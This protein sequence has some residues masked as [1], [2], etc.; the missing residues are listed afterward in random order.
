VGAW[1]FPG[2]PLL[3]RFT[4]ADFKA[5]PYLFG[6]ARDAEGRLYVGNTDGVLRM[7]GRE[8]ETISLPGGMAGGSLARGEDGRV[9]LAGY[10]SFG[11]IDTAADGRAVYHDLRDAFGLKGAARSLG[12]MGQVLPVADGIYF[13]S[14]H[15]LLFYGFSGGCRQWRVAEDNS[16]FSDW[17]GNLYTLNKDIVLQRLDG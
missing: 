12:W 3:Q 15:S 17:H 6:V 8:W 2:E 14:Q 11:Y 5:L 16:G 13:R 10:D 4:P 1:A 7:Q 9:Y